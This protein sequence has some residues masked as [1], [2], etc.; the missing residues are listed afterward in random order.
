MLFTFVI[1]YLTYFCNYC[2]SSNTSIN[3]N[4]PCDLV[5]HMA[6]NCRNGAVTVSIHHITGCAQIVTKNGICHNHILYQT[7]ENCQ[8]L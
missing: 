6:L 3:L 4:T 7:I 8:I 1:I 5:K 2:G